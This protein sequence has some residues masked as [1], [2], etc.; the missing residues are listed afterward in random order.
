MLLQS[1]LLR[2]IALFIV[3]GYVIIFISLFHTP[4]L[5]FSGGANNVG[6]NG[7]AIVALNAALVSKG[8]ENAALLQVIDKLKAQLA[9]S[10]SPSDNL[11]K[12]VEEPA[13]KGGIAETPG[14]IVLGMHRSGTSILGGLLN[15]MG[16]KAG[17]P[18]IQPANDNEKGFFERVDVVLQNDALMKSQRVHYGSRTESYD[19]LTGTLHALMAIQGSAPGLLGAN[20]ARLL[21]TI[22][23]G[24][25]VGDKVYAL[26]AKSPLLQQPRN[27]PQ[28]I[29]S[30]DRR[31]PPLELKDNFFNEGKRGLSF[32]NNPGNAPWML[33]DPRL[34]ITLRTWLPLLNNIPAIVFTYRHPLDVAMSLHKRQ[35]HYN[36]GKGLKLW[37]VYNKRAIQQSND[38]CRVV[39]SHKALIKDGYGELMR[40]GIY[41]KEY[42]GYVI[43]DHM[44]SLSLS[45]LINGGNNGGSIGV[46]QKDINEFI[47]PHLQHSSSQDDVCITIKKEGEASAMA[48]LLPPKEKWDTADRG[49]VV[50]YREVMRVYCNMEDGTAFSADYNWDESIKDS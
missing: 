7:E 2:G 20:Q 18:L 37:Y 26:Y 30:H 44:H 27:N 25:A 28:L 12:V 13:V 15:K 1:N 38:L 33:K 3:L 48:A 34:C 41:L 47:D 22:P 4:A 11:P 42:C 31:V 24:M 45:S 16:A 8:Q 40:I 32:L 9:S 23:E 46:T 29:S 10:S 35:E 49:H 36:V 5:P 19:A 39:T 21:T 14:I 50:L 6:G 43:N 17:Q